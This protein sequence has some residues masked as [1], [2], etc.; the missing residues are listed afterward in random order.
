M[1]P[2]F[3]T[4]APHWRAAAT[5]LAGG[6]AVE[7]CAQYWYLVYKSFS[8]AALV[9]SSALAT[10]ARALTTSSFTS[11]PHTLAVCAN[12]DDGSEIAATLPMVNRIRAMRNRMW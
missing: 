1:L 7:S 9:A 2:R 8:K 11:G 10:V 5:R 12:A 6:E 3:E 4:I